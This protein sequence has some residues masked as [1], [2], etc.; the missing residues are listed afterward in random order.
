M[1]FESEFFEFLPKD[2]IRNHEKLSKA[3]IWGLDPAYPKCAGKSVI[4][5]TLMRARTRCFGP[6]IAIFRMVCDLEWQMSICLWKWLSKRKPQ[7]RAFG[8]R[9]PNARVNL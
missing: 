8:V 1:D 7:K 3:R 6:S 9:T 4:T 2:K 5:E